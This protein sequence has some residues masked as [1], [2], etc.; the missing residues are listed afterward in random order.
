MTY[1]HLPAAPSLPGPDTGHRC[2]WEVVRHTILGGRR[3]VLPFFRCLLRR[4]RTARRHQILTPIPPHPA[5]YRA[6][7]DNSCFRIDPPHIAPVVIQGGV[8]EFAVHPAHAGDETIGLDGPHDDT[9]FGIDL[10]NLRLRS[11]RPTTPL[12]PRQGPKSAP[13]PGAGMLERTFPVSRSTF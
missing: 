2:A 4:R 5:A 13:P 7:Q 9:R 10:V 6:S 12:P 3:M 1:D 8:P 11:A